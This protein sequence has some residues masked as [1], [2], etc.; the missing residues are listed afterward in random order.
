[1]KT[2]IKK[3]WL[4]G[5]VNK[6]IKGVDWKPSTIAKF[7]SI[8]PDCKTAQKILKQF[9]D[10]FWI[11]Y[12][13]YNP[14]WPMWEYMVLLKL[15]SLKMLKVKIWRTKGGDRLIFNNPNRT[16][17]EHLYDVIYDMGVEAGK[18]QT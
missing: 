13:P 15:A 3:R 1:M 9:D 7:K 8:S 10:T 11:P 14:Q 2:I 12:K 5:D 17:F 16:A 6:I 18:N 4:C